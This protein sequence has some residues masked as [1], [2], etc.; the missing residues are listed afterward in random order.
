MADA[1]APGTVFISYSHQDIV[2][3]ARLQQHLASHVRSGAIPLREDTQLKAGS[4]WGRGIEQTLTS[5]CVALLLVSVCL[6]ILLYSLCLLF[7]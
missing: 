6:P 3:L 4:D 1:P 7:L 5:T 2:Y